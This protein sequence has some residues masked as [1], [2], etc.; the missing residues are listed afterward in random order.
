[1]ERELQYGVPAAV[2]YLDGGVST[3]EIGRDWTEKKLLTEIRK[4]ASV[5]Q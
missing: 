2:Y 5:T 4:L 1:M 3:D